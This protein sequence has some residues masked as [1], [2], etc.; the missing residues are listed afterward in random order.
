MSGVAALQNRPGNS[1]FPKAG[2]AATRIKLGGGL[3]QLGVAANTMVVPRLPMAFVLAGKGA[4]CGGFAGDF[5]GYGLSVFVSQQ[6]APLGI[7][8]LDRKVH[9]EQLISI[10]DAQSGGKSA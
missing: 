3:K 10:D 6:G 8:F 1:L 4:L 5:K 2:P 9:E 7:G